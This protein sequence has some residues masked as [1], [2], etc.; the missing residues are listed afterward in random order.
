MK[1]GAGAKGKLS[2][3]DLCEHI[4]DVRSAGVGERAGRE[5]PV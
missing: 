1:K 5:G 3:T 4:A 2:K